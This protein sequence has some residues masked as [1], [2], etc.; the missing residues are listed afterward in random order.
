MLALDPLPIVNGIAVLR[1]MEPNDL[2]E[3]QAYRGD[4][5]VGRYQGWSVMSADM[6]KAFL[7]EMNVCQLM[8]P[9]TWVQ[10][11]ISEPA[12]GLLLG[13]IGLRLSDSQD[14]AEVGF[15]LAP[16]AQS[17]GIATAA[18][19][20]AIEFVFLHTS[21]ERVLGI[22]DAR[23]SAS[24]RLLERVGMVKLG[25]TSVVFKGESCTEDRYA[26]YRDSGAPPS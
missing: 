17:R 9:G 16:H 13:D 12:S 24:I 5:A 11:G 3:F 14:E 2:A 1:R 15:T 22:T 10:L 8:Q 23:N 25:S 4:P 21:A 7:S 18:V 26:K 20:A 6:A 19:S